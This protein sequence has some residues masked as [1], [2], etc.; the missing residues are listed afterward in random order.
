MELQIVAVDVIHK[1]HNAP[2]PC[3]D[4]LD[5]E[6]AI[7]IQGAIEQLNCTPPFLKSFISNSGIM[8]SHPLN[9]TCSQDKLLDF[10]SKYD[11]EY[12]FDTVAKS[13]DPPCTEM[14]TIVS[15]TSVVIPT[16]D[17]SSTH[18][19]DL[20]TSRMTTLDLDL[21]YNV[22]LSLWSQVGGFI[23][24]F[25]G[26]SLLQMPDLIECALVWSK[27]SLTHLVQKSKEF[28]AYLR[29]EELHS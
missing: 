3:D 19:G 12:N 18:S 4:N 11:P 8:Q 26:Y 15:S 27:T 24:I 21:R 2:Q 5:N 29:N 20:L 25:L 23:G 28:I 10:D 9:A 22:H 1:R 16:T 14:E 17:Y 7:W 13:Y 6:D